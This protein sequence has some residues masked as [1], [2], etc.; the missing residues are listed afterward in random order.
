MAHYD[1]HELCADAVAQTCAPDSLVSGRT[2]RRSAERFYARTVGSPRT[3]SRRRVPTFRTRCAPE[4]SCGTALASLAQNLPVA[5]CRWSD[6]KRSGTQPGCS[7][8]NR[9]GP[10][11]TGT[12][13]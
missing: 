11:V 13:G 7:H 10:V 9:E 12:R 5:A 4:T 3:E 2:D 1:C 6:H 8:W